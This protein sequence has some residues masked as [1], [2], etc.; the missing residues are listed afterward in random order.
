MEDNDFYFIYVVV[1]PSFIKT[2]IHNFTSVPKN[3]NVVVITNTP[4]LLDGVKT[5]FNLIV[6]DLE[7]LRDD[8]SIEHEKIV[9]A[10]DNEDYVKAFMELQRNGARFP[11]QI[12]RYGIKWA[13]LNNVTKF[14]V[15]ESGMTIGLDTDPNVMISELKKMGE[16]NNVLFGNPYYGSF[17]WGK[18]YFNVPKF[19]DILKKYVDVENYPTTINWDGDTN[20]TGSVSFEG[21]MLGHWFHDISLVELCFNVYSEVVEASYG[22]QLDSLNGWAD[23]FEWISTILTTMF[24]KYYNTRINGHW[25]IVVHVYHPEE[26]YFMPDGRL[27]NGYKWISTESRD[28]FIMKN[29]EELLNIFGGLERAKKLCY[30]FK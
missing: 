5:D 21:G 11:M 10:E 9:Y 17:D 3:C 7:S 20:F 23:S 13:A 30:D 27:I 4:Q 16:T 18:E 19:R 15:L 2:I 6:V 14:V 29:R 28:E 25:Q 12:M 26:A 22:A 24:S 1:G 8:W